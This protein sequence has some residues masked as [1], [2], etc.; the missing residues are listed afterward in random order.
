[1][2]EAKLAR[3]ADL[4]Y[5]AVGMVTDYDCWHADHDAV[6]VADIVR[7]LLENADHARSLVKAVAPCVPDLPR[8]CPCGC[9]RVLDDAIIT[10]ADARDPETMHRLDA[11]LGR[12]LNNA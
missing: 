9:H 6:Q 1:M 2:P 4:C 8:P 10:A 11:V 5:A 3:E 12:V 7:V